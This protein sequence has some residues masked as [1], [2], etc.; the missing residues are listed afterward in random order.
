MTKTSLTLRL[1]LVASLFVGGAAWAG[2]T[3]ADVLST[4]S[5]LS[6]D[7]YAQTHLAAIQDAAAPI[8]NHCPELKTR[9]TRV[10]FRFIYFEAIGEDKWANLV[11]KK[12]GWASSVTIQWNGDQF[13]SLGQGIDGAPGSIFAYGA[14][15]QKWC[16]LPTAPLGQESGPISVKLNIR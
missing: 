8:L 12:R 4:F 13:V 6:T 1:A 10:K 11:L 2:E 3:T 5:P 16:G 9:L 7:A 14:F 15:A